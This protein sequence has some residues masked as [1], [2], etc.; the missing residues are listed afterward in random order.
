MSSRLDTGVAAI[1][2]DVE[3]HSI[4]ECKGL[5]SFS[6]KEIVEILDGFPIDR[7]SK[8]RVDPRERETNCL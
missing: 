4:E 8:F 2:P 6:I 3:S 7:C 5:K 1:K